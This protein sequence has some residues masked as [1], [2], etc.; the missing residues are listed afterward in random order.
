MGTGDRNATS[1]GAL[2]VMLAFIATI[3]LAWSPAGADAYYWPTGEPVISVGQTVVMYSDHYKSFCY[4]E[5]YDATM[6]SDT[7]HIKC[8]V[9]KNDIAQA[10]R[11]L[12]EPSYP[13][14]VCGRIPMTLH[15]VSV[16]LTTR[17]RCYDQRDWAICVVQLRANG[18]HTLN[19]R[20]TTAFPSR[21]NL[22][23]RNVAAPS[24]GV[25]GW[26]H[27]GQMPITITSGFTGSACAL[28]GSQGEI[29]CVGYQP[30][31]A[32]L[33]YLVPVDPITPC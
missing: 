18:D 5:D 32:S 23:L 2:L 12:I 1:H 33:F 10:S 3:A 9:S 13:L 25:D 26:L 14:D 30:S 27:G 8:N 6:S 31:Q 22:M 20:A 15:N 21:S 24:G 4:W 29:N 19:C 7:S 11:F 28:V 17:G 16:S